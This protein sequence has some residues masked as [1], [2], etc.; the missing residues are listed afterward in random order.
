MFE[1]ST[2]EQ[3]GI[4]H[5]RQ[6]GRS[7]FE[8]FQDQMPGLIG[9]LKTGKYPS[10]I[11]HIEHLDEPEDYVDPDLAFG[12]INQVKVW[13]SRMAIVCPDNLLDVVEPIA[14][15]VRNHRKP[16]RKFT[17]LADA[18]HWLEHDQ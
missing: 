4:L 3:S 18:L 7:T 16:V 9:S 5:L 11:L 15:V 1:Y 8:D 12:A 10:L 6:V 14:E 13:I 17:Q 2:D